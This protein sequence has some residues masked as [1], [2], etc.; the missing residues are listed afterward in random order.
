MTTD[1]KEV[2]RLID[3]VVEEV[4]LVDRAANQH[5][6]LIVKRRDEM[7]DA[8]IQPDQ[9]VAKETSPQPTDQADA[10]HSQPA[11]GHDHL[12]KTESPE[13]GPRP[14]PTP[15]PLSEDERAA[16]QSTPDLALTS[17]QQAVEQL[18]EM[19]REA[20]AKAAPEA[21]P[22]AATPEGQDTKLAGELHQLRAAIQAQGQR[23]AQLEKRAGLP[24]S[25]PVEKSTTPSEPGDVGWPLDLNQSF[26]RSTVDKAVSFHDL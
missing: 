13:D 9:G 26:D 17:L 25:T 12:G 4:S 15:A 19:L 23:I 21:T 7:P 18:T 20:K 14:A 1:R 6:F 22:P 24:N 10:P 2:Q 5:R 11:E 8:P 16:E 3:I